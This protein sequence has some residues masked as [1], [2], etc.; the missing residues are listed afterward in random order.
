MTYYF[1]NNAT[2][3]MSQNTIN[4]ITGYFNKGNPSSEFALECKDVMTS[5]IKEIKKISGDTN[6]NYELIITSGATESNCTFLRMIHSYYKSTN[7]EKGNSYAFFSE[8]EFIVSSI[9]HKSI[10]SCLDSIS[11]SDNNFIT[12]YIYPEGGIIKASTLFNKLTDKTKVVIVMFANNETGGINEIHEIANICKSRGILFFCDC[13]QSYGKFGLNLSDN[14]IDSFSISFHKIYGP[15]GVGILGI[16]KDI[17]KK[18]NLDKYSIINGTQNDGLRGGTENIPAIAGALNGLKETFEERLYKNGYL[19]YLGNE[20]I[21]CISTKMQ[22]R[23]FFPSEKY[24][25]LSND[26]ISSRNNFVY[27][28]IISPEEKLPNTLLVSF[29]KKGKFICNK[30]IQKKLANKGIIIGLG[31]ACNKNKQSYVLSACGIPN[32]LCSSVIRISWSDFTTKKEVYKLCE[33]LSRI[34]N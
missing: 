27:F 15:T 5:L 20:L 17:L 18:Y 4:T 23:S 12:S 16:R 7:R 24:K 29:Y 25:M 22:I 21:N 13:T 34:V 10:L 11:N 6:D 26:D 19:N 3:M 14:L 9:E 1:D 32:Y 2:T 30:V 28:I 31:S 8:I 33:E